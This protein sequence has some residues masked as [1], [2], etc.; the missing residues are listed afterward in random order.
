M[1]SGSTARDDGLASRVDRIALSPAR[2]GRDARR[3]G[4]RSFGDLSAAIRPGDR[5]EVNLGFL[6]LVPLGRD[7]VD[8]SGRLVAE[9][10]AADARVVPV[11]DEDRAIGRRACIDRP[12][13]RVV[14]RQED[15][16]LGPERRPLAGEREE[17]DLPRAGVD[18][19]DAAAVL[20][21]AAGSP[22]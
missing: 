20:A 12:E 22:S 6:A 15:L 14:A 16:V 11:G 4:W 1:R 17:V 9:G 5:R 2:S 7:A 21:G 13:P 19:E 18:L 8:P 10:M 3:P